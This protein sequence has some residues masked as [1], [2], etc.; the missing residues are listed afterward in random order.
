MWV[1]FMSDKQEDLGQDNN[2]SGDAFQANAA[3][4]PDVKPMDNNVDDDEVKPSEQTDYRSVDNGMTSVGSTSQNSDTAL[5]G[6]TDTPGVR[7]GSEV[8]APGLQDVDRKMEGPDAEEIVHHESDPIAGDNIDDKV[9]GGFV[10][11]PA[12]T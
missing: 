9:G 12:N 8:K 3:M 10:N 5:L 1:I 11:D 2:Y 7:M 4:N 6:V